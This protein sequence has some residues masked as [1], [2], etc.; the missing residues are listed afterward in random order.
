MFEQL[1][2]DSFLALPILGWAILGVVVLIV[3]IF[4]A[5]D[6]LS[7]LTTLVGLAALFGYSAYSF[8][9][10]TNQ[11]VALFS[12]TMVLDPFGQFLNLV[13]LIIVMAVAMISYAGGYSQEATLQKAHKQYPE[14]LICLLFSAFGCMVCV[15]AVDL[16]S[17]FLGIETLS[18]GL[19]ALC[20]FYRQEERST[21]SALKYLLVGAFSTV[22][23]LY[24]ISF[25]YGTV[26]STNY[27]AIAAAIA[28][29]EANLVLLAG[30]FLVVGLAFKLALIPFHLYTPDVYEGA[31]TS[32]T[33]YLATV[34]KVAAVGAGVRLFWGVLGN[35]SL[36]WEPYWIA[37][38]AISVLVGNIAAL[39]QRTIKKL[40]AFSSIS[41]AGF[42]GLGVLVAQ[43][44]V[45]DLF[46]LGSYLFIY[47]TM[48]LGM[49]GL[50]ALIEKR[51]QEFLVEDLRGLGLKKVGLGILFSILALS[52]AG[53]PP[54]AGFMIKFWVFQ[55]LI[56]QG[57]LGLS[58][59][60]VVG[61]IIGVFYY[62]RILM[63][64]FMSE[65]GQEGAAIN[66]AGLSDKVFSLRTVI[67][68]A[69]LVSMIGGLKPDF[70]ADI[71][72]SVVAQR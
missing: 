34:V 57:H 54:F 16:T 69:V 17:F 22:V 19:Y 64:L 51:D 66:W 9:L 15:T 29:A 52:L 14:F 30:I 59:F 61:S 38:C 56:E 13:T 27:A 72:M 8:Y 31:P 36:A 67:F 55:G 63:L 2:Q 6:R 45:G 35:Q 47:V 49:F 33:A 46:A 20:G 18:I 41:H 25:L 68:L 3:Q 23:L 4:C 21:E 32:V 26:G 12:S 50:V 60:A 70:Y 37:L 58:L 53:I 42:L 5:N 44:G 40:L 43:P 24:G 39:Q 62:L 7:F 71:V 1:V 28:A 48:T 11:N 10:D 65:E